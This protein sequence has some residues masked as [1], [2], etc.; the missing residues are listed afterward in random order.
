MSTAFDLEKLP[1]ARPSTFTPENSVV[2]IF[3]IHSFWTQHMETL[4]QLTS[5][6]INYQVSFQAPPEGPPRM[7]APKL[8]DTFSGDRYTNA[9]LKPSLARTL[10]GRYLE[11]ELVC[12]PPDPVLGLQAVLP[13]QRHHRLVQTPALLSLQLQDEHLQ[14]TQDPECQRAPTRLTGLLGLW[15]SQGSAKSQL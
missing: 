15:P 13:R 5:A 12:G 8:L 7:G 9:N 6:S 1:K 11:C 2:T 4:P 10:A 14:G 3:I